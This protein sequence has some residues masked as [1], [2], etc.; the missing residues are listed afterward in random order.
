MVVTPYMEGQIVSASG[1]VLDVS[2]PFFLANCISYIDPLAGENFVFV[3]VYLSFWSIV[4]VSKTAPQCSED[5]DI[6]SL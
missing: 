6:K 5:A 4:K 3:F 2:L 1:N